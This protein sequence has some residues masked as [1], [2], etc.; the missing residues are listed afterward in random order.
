M[1]WPGSAVISQRSDKSTSDYCLGRLTEKFGMEQEQGFSQ[2]VTVS[3]IHRY[4]NFIK[5]V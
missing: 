5:V 4:E 1:L 2:T 3:Q